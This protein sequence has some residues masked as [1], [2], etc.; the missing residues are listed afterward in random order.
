MT[1]SRRFAK[2]GVVE[3]VPANLEERLSDGSIAVAKKT[4][5]GKPVKLAVGWSQLS[6]VS[7]GEE[8]AETHLDPY[9]IREG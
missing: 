2:A 8:Q 6:R 5:I 4:P 7:N 9:T 1:S 3:G